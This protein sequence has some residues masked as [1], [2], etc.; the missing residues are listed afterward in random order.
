MREHTMPTY[1]FEMAPLS[2][3]VV[4]ERTLVHQGPLPRV[5]FGEYLEA[6]GISWL[7]FDID[8]A[9]NV[10][11]P[12]FPRPTDAELFEPGYTIEWED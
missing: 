4:T 10:L 3:F 7:A 2:D 12:H 5:R 11:K 8:K 1:S 9:R 6:N